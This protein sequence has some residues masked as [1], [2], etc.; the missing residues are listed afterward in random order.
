MQKGKLFRKEKKYLSVLLVP[1]SVDRVKTLKFKALYSKIIVTLALFI[2]MMICMVSL[3]VYNMLE[4]NKLKSDISVLSESNLEQRKLIWEKAAEIQGHK[5]TETRFNN[6]KKDFL[7][8][9]RELAE[10]FIEDRVDGEKINRG[11]S[12]SKSILS[13]L[14]HL[15]GIL[16]NLNNSTATGNPSKSDLS[17]TEK[18][19]TGY[20]ESVP[21]RWPAQ[22]E[23]SSNF[24]GRTDPF[25]FIKR[26]HTGLD[27]VADYGNNIRASAS[28]TVTFAGYKGAY[29]YTVIIDHGHGL[30]TFYGHSSVL[31]VKEGQSV[32]KGDVIARIGSTGRST[33]PHLHFEVRFNGE[34]V[35]P[36]KYLDSK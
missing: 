14:D 29:G 23:I 35:D 24:G 31:L 18:K 32:K 15:K 11:E 7:D 3:L 16:D 5:E 12:N 22:G 17:E 34:P 1:H 19:L 4:N 21:T 27:I 13:D 30:S 20:L 33:G 36:L 6:C 26:Y 25:L 8:K 10:K 2:V 9:Y 28:G